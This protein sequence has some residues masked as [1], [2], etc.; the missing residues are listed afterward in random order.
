MKVI[1]EQIGEVEGEVRFTEKHLE[2]SVLLTQL[3]PEGEAA[4]IFQN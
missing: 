1:T 4:C 3:L 2:E